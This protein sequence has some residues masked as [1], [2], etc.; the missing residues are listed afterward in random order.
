MRTPST[1]SLCHIP[2]C[3]LAALHGGSAPHS[4]PHMRA[5]PPCWAAIWSCLQLQTGGDPFSHLPQQCKG[6][7]N[8]TLG[9]GRV[10]SPSV[11]A[12]L[13]GPWD[14]AGSWSGT[15]GEEQVWNELGKDAGVQKSHAPCVKDK[16]MCAAS[17][18]GYRGTHHRVLGSCSP[19]PISQ[20][21]VVTAFQASAALA[22]PAAPKASQR[23][24]GMA[25]LTKKSALPSTPWM[26]PG[27]P[28]REGAHQHPRC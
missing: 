21:T 20:I 27:G 17:R 10:S 26:C 2:Q 5:S 14:L 7:N 13:G 12:V 18:L 9:G 24:K 11:P 22:L 1:A 15:D 8:R 25:A 19:S 6:Q 28:C 23:G 3:Q 16:L 4:Q